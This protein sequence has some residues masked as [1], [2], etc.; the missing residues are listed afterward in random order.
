MT[1]RTYKRIDIDASSPFARR[2][3]SPPDVATIAVIGLGYVGLPLAI[4]AASRGFSVI[5]FDY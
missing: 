1:V 5:G 4:R 2:T 3:S